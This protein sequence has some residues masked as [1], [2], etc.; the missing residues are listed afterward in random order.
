MTSYESSEV[1]AF[2]L[3]KRHLPRSQV[4]AIPD[5]EDEEDQDA[6]AS[7]PSSL[8]A[9]F[10]P[11]GAEF[12][13][14][15]PS[16]YSRYGSFREQSPFFSPVFSH[17]PS[18]RPE[19]L[20]VA[21]PE[22]QN[23]R[24]KLMRD[25]NVLIVQGGYEGKRF[26]YDRLR[27][28]GVHIY[29]MD[30]PGSIW[31]KVADEGGI[32]EFIEID[33]TAYDTLFERAMEAI[34]DCTLEGR[35]DA[36]TTYYEDAVP[37][38]ARIATALGVNTN[39]IESCEKARN[40]RMTRQTMAEAGLPVPRFKRILSADDIQPACDYV[41]FPVILKPVFGAASMGVTLAQSVQEAA[42]AYEK[43][44]SSFDVNDDTIWA[45]GTEMVIEEYYDGD[46]FDIDVL[47][48]EGTVVYAKV[49]D[50]WACW[51]PWFQETGTNCPSSYPVDKQT[52]LIKLAIETTMALGFRNGCFHVELRYTKRGPRLIE[53]NARMGG[54]SVRDANLLAWGVDLVEEHCM[55]A[56]KIPIRP[57]IPK[58]PLK[59]MAESAI[60]A[61]Y[62]GVLNE[63]DWL[64][65]A[66][67]SKLVLKTSY[68]KHKGDKVC[69]PEDGLPDWIAEIIVV[70]E[71]STEEA[72]M[73]IRRIVEKCKVPIT[74][75][76]AGTER[77]FFF[78]GHS[79]PFC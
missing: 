6:I 49:S 37:L 77:R 40:K 9:N 35:F 27:S 48:S 63:N 11:P 47:L 46:E 38:A 57:A 79:H 34:M 14:F 21:S 32:A 39:S 16:A 20:R 58:E 51:E 13:D 41:G 30:G 72:V 53:V 23:L 56:L 61:P 50:N 52:E 7:R 60:N 74:A 67:K 70:S 78:P 59:F 2:A 26:I 8:R 44:F 10:F 19:K 4:E 15:D 62:S 54:V 43:L 29:M 12:G 17:L 24:R 45:Q 69:G 3:N 55:T 64:A 42:Q 22:T 66:R 31:K 33:F 68:L 36:V 65:F 1:V 71:I 25:S 28:L 75:S 73:E 5:I 76:V 18:V